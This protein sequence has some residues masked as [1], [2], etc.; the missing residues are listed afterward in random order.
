M[1]NFI[2]TC[3]T[4]YQEIFASLNF[5]EN[6]DCNNFANDPRGQHKRC[7]M[8]IFAKF[9]FATEQNSQNS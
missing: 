6:G 5:R 8:A 2:G 1:Y 4:V 3:S 9:N 7:G